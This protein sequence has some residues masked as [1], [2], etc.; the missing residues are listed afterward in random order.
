VF[1]PNAYALVIDTIAFGVITRSP[2]QF[3]LDSDPLNF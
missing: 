1:S 3:G 2:R